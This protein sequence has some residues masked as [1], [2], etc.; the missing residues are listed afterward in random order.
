MGL[1]T[2]E[3][4]Y[5][6]GQII[7]AS[8]INELTAA[9]LNQVVGR[10]SSGVP[11]SGKS[12]GTAAIPWGPMHAASL[13]LNGQVVDPSTITTVQNRIVSGKTR[14]DSILPMFLKAHGTAATMTVEGATTELTL[15]INGSAV[16]VSTDIVKTGLTLAPSANNTC[17][18]NDTTMVSDKYAG[19]DG[20]VITIDTLGSEVTAKVGQMVAF[21]INTEIFWGYLK[22]STEITNVFR[23][24]FFDS[25]Q[26][27]IVRE[28]LSD[29]DT[30]TIL[31]M[32]WCFIEDNGTTVDFSYTTPV[33]QYEAPAATT[34]AYWFDIPNQTWKR[35]SGTE[36]EIVGRILIGMAVLDDSYCIATRS[37]DF[38]L[39][40]SDY[41]SITL[42]ILTSERVQSKDRQ[43]LASVY[44]N[45]IT[46]YLNP[47]DWDISTD[48]ETG[49]SQ[50]AGTLY[51][52]YLTEKG[53]RVISD[54]RPH[55]RADLKGK[56]HPFHSW[57]NVGSC[58][59][60]SSSNIINVAS[61]ASVE[62]E[63]VGA[64]LTSASQD[65]P[66]NHLLCDG[67]SLLKT[68]FPELFKKLGISYGSDDADHF[69]IPDFRGKFLRG[70][71]D[72]AGVDVG[73]IFGISQDDSFQGHYHQMMHST[74]AAGSGAGIQYDSRGGP[75]TQYDITTTAT[76]ARAEFEGVNGVPRTSDET[77]PINETVNYFIRYQ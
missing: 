64:L 3:T 43:S 36:W 42:E 67:A 12:L 65:I 59:N 58:F 14:S 53:Q 60:D 7:D 54:E 38:T 57:R 27:P 15:S 28:G 56:Y 41:N 16:S 66:K 44:A 76:A 35:Y 33:Y 22:S 77:R 50:S 39:N 74:P 32:A 26:A 52:L 8:N 51:Y 34:G 20:S 13:I 73:R 5:S 40:Y 63:N 23:G 17:L 2:L 24:F 49:L 61:T 62:S 9:S 21:K 29:N 31:N 70:F 18:V 46:Q 72:G 11:E 71:D 48:L 30:L 10:N 6:N 47:L 69:N 45:D 25:A 75:A 4:S 68:G 37:A 19:E 1:N 55:C